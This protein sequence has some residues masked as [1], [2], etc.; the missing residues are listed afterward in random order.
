LP[1]TKIL[2]KSKTVSQTRNHISQNQVIKIAQI[3]AG[4]NT[5]AESSQEKLRRVTTTKYN[6]KTFLDVGLL[7]DLTGGLTVME[8]F[9]KKIHDGD[10]YFVAG[11]E[12]LDADNS[13]NFAVTTPD[14][15]TEIHM[16]FMT[17]GVSRTEVY[18]YE[19]AEVSGGTTATPINNNR[20]ST[21]TSSLTIAKNPTINTQG[22]LIYSETRGLE[23]TNKI[24]SLSA[25]F[26]RSRELVLK[27]NSTY[28]FQIKSKEDTNHVSYLGSWYELEEVT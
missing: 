1:R 17:N 22:T 2:G 10:N 4:Y 13:I 3:I 26:G 25:G 21:N 11:F 9:H 18:V 12:T 23:G 6:D 7:D 24:P 28:I 15:N 14:S 16:S 27:R 8:H 20:N 19:D 5:N